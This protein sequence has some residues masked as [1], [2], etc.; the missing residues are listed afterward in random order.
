MI[1]HYRCRLFCYCSNQ[2]AMLKDKP[3]PLNTLT[4]FKPS[5][6]SHRFLFFP[7]IVICKTY[8]IEIRTIVASDFKLRAFGRGRILSRP[9]QLARH[10]FYPIV[11]FCL[12]FFFLIPFILF[13]YWLALCNYL[14][15]FGRCD[16]WW[17]AHRECTYACV[18]V[19]FW[20]CQ[21]RIEVSDGLRREF[22][23]GLLGK[24]HWGAACLWIL[25][26]IYLFVLIISTDLVQ[27][28][29]LLLLR[30]VVAIFF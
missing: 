16:Y 30:N 24:V 14:C 2:I 3:P 27:I 1:K 29:W 5:R 8:L 26:F 23:V 7:I 21:W 6:T 12:S 17:L 19:S 25:L 11:C 9:F 28:Q 15:C 4:D 10:C 13:F 18:E 20:L 22:V